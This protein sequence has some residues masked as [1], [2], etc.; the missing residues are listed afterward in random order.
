M[1]DCSS[2]PLRS[3]YMLPTVS[4][5]FVKMNGRLF[6][7]HAIVEL[8]YFQKFFEKGHQVALAVSI[9]LLNCLSQAGNTHLTISAVIDESNVDRRWH[10]HGHVECELRAA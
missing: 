1:S 8:H 10:E 9:N 3:E 6:Y 5:V 7:E 4:T 2:Q